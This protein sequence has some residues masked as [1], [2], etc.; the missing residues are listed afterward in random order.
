MTGPGLP[1][2]VVLASGNEHKLAELSAVLAG[3]GLA[4]VPQSEFEIAAVA[5]TGTTFIENALIKARHA[6]SAA[7]LPALA[8]DSGL[9]VFALDG[10]PGIHSARYAGNGDDA[11]N[12]AKL[13]E[14]LAGVPEDRRGARF[15]CVIVLLR[16]ATDPTPLVCQAHWD[17]RILESPRGGRGFG[18]D[19]LF[20]VPTHGCSAA[21]L[22]PD[23]KNRISHRG[24]ALARLKRALDDK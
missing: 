6:A 14:A 9:E 12:N 23:E 19:P 15:H 4:L 3:S 1:E 16:H 21:E 7:D 13:L 5:E 18:Y 17:G 11:A 20:W 2:R 24:Q 22:D 8:D 10:E